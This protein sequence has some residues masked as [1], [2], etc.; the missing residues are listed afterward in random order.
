MKGVKKTDFLQ[1]VQ[2]PTDSLSLQALQERTALLQEQE[3]TVKR[4][5]DLLSGLQ[6]GLENWFAALCV[7]EET[8]AKQEKY[9]QELENQICTSGEGVRKE[10]R[11]AAYF[12]LQMRILEQRIRELERENQ[13]LQEA[14]RTLLREL[15]GKEGADN[16]Q[17]HGH[18]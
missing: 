13:E 17:I 5:R 4:E 2:K 6:K 1:P 16:G 18:Q 15:C 3:A 11:N 14:K 7:R 9:L 10:H 8:L 12:R